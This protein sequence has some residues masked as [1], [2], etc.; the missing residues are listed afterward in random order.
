MKHLE[1]TIQDLA[2]ELAQEKINKNYV[3]NQLQDAQNKIQELEVKLKEKE[4]ENE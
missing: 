1:Q 3:I 2:I 4:N